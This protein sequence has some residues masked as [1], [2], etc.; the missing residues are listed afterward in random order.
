MA[1]IE[2]DG[3]TVCSSAIRQAVQA[4][5]LSRAREMLGRPFA[6]VGQ[7]VRG[8]GRGA[9]LQFPTI[10]LAPDNEILPGEGVYVSETIVLAGRHLSVTNVGRRPTF[11]GET[12]LVETH[13][14]EF[15]GDLYG[16]RVE[17]RLLERLREE[18]RFSNATELSDQIAR[19][20]AAAEAFFQNPR[21]RPR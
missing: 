13:L 20:C 7:V 14:L 11:D 17:V 6:L 4:G 2:L 8:E 3:E 18:M 12:T 10:N 15:E 5:Q 19:D 21:L 9:R 16:E 1:P